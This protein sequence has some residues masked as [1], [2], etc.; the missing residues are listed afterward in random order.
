ME[1]PPYNKKIDAIYKLAD[2]YC[3]FYLKW[4]KS[5]PASVFKDDKSQYW[6]LMSTSQK[7]KIWSGYAFEMLCY[8]NIHLLKKALDIA[9]VLT[10]EG[11][12]K[13]VPSQKSSENGAQIDLV[14]DRKDGVISICEM[15]FQADEFIISKA[16]AMNLE[17]KITVFKEKTK[18]QF[19]W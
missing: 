10:S 3:Y 12:W 6:K 1:L 18:K 15:K 4:I 11:P 5:A 7:W 13:Y 2:E 16:Y 19:F 8:K 9:G 17:N 14:I